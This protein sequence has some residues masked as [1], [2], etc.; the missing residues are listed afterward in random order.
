MSDF[1]C[2]HALLSH[3]TLLSL[4]LSRK[5]GVVLPSGSGIMRARPAIRSTVLR[6]MRVVASGGECLQVWVCA[7]MRLRQPGSGTAIVRLLLQN[8]LGIASRVTQC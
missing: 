2:M 5:T 6:Y 4:N 7:S 8:L 1:T 3:M